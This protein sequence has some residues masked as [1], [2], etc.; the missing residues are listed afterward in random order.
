MWAFLK[1]LLWAQY[2]VQRNVSNKVLKASTIL[3]II[4]NVFWYGMFAALAVALGY[5]TMLLQ[6][7]RLE[8]VLTLGF[9]G[10]TI[11]WQFFPLLMAS[12]GIYLDIRRLLVYPIPQRYL[13][14]LEGALRISTSLEM[15]LV[16]LGITVGMA[17]NRTLPKYAPLVGIG[18]LVLNLLISTGMKAY[19][20]RMMK[21]KWFR[22]IFMFGFISLLVVPQFLGSFE[23]GRN[24]GAFLRDMPNVLP[25]AFLGAL[26]VGRNVAW[27]GAILVGA[28]AVAAVGSYWLFLQSLRLQ[29]FTASG[30][31]GKAESKPMGEGGPLQQFFRLPSRFL[32]DP[33]GAIAEKELRTLFRSPRFRLLLLLGCVVGVALWSPMGSRGT[34]G[35]SYILLA[36]GYSLL[37]LGE[38]I[39]WNIFGLDRGASQFWFVTPLAGRAV[40]L[41]KNASA[42][43]ILF[44][45]FGV[46]CLLCAFLPF[47]RYGWAGLLKGITVVLY[48]GLILMGAGNLTSITSPRAIDPENAWRNSAGGWQQFLLLLIYPL[49]SLPVMLAGVAEWATGEPL[50]YLGV[51]GANMLVGAVFYWVALDEAITRLPARQEEMVNALTAEGRSSGPLS[52]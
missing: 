32:P 52:I 24:V 6:G 15:V 33:I 28:L 20:D 8:R 37:T 26:A 50:Y 39:I 44:F 30:G 25:T 21:R 47:A 48:T 35:P 34:I 31:E 18:F 13:F 46:I 17:L 7:V 3:A 23:A 42:W 45:A 2:C 10:I 5:V 22:E 40:L 43:I 27:N 49:L 4:S 19:L 9:L 36:Y 29:E 41:A 11:F 16:T 51:M 38:V 14:F 1:T 12:A